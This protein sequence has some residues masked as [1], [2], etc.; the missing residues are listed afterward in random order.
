MDSGGAVG[1]AAAGDAGTGGPQ[2]LID[3]EYEPAFLRV[4]PFTPMRELN[5]RKDA[6]HWRRAKRVRYETEPESRRPVNE[7][8]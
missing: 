4:W 2:Y 8:G 5:S 6:H 1:G 3:H 7:P